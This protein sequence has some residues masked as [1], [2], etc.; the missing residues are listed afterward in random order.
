MNSHPGGVESILRKAGGVQDCS[1]DLLFHSRAGMKVWKK[2]KVGKLRE[3]KCEK[4]D[5]AD[6]D[7]EMNQHWWMSWLR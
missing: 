7:D 2:F 3:C 4:E 6:D 5:S 1:K